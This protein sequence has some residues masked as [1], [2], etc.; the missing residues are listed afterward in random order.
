[1]KKRLRASQACVASRVASPLELRSSKNNLDIARHGDPPRESPD[2]EASAFSHPARP[3]EFRAA[4]SLLGAI[5]RPLRPPLPFALSPFLLGSRTRFSAARCD[6]VRD[7]D[8]E[9]TRYRSSRRMATGI[10]GRVGRSSFPPPSSAES[11]RSRERERE[12]ENYLT[13]VARGQNPTPTRLS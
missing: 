9:N 10:V 4:P 7:N 8:R 1:M 12:R 13:Y 2:A 3:T 6:D 11:R 5:N